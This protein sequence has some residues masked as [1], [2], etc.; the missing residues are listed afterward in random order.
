MA[1]T[2][3]IISIIGLMGVGKSTLGAK[4]AERLG[5]YFVDSDEEIEDNQRKTIPEIFA[6]NGEKYFRE[7]ERNIIAEIIKRDEPMVISLGGGAFVDEKTRK[8]LLEKTFVIWLKAPIDVIMHRI[9]NKQNR[10]LLN[11]SDKRKTLQ[12]LLDSRE[13]I[14]ATADLEI[15]ACEG[16]HDFLIEKIIRVRESIAKTSKK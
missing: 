12:D 7:V 2:A 5:F 8:A 15:D 13:E 14:Y 16:N 3:K 11:N 9:G 6:S 1:K 4:L 10:P